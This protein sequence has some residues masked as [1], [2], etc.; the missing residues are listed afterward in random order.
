MQQGVL[1]WPQPTVAANRFVI[2][3]ILF[4]Q[5]AHRRIIGVAKNKPGRGGQR[6]GIPAPAVIVK[7]PCMFRPEVKINC[8]LVCGVCWRAS[9]FAAGA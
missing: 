3:Q 9:Q 7:A 4:E 8:I 6:L 5:A 2:G 1:E